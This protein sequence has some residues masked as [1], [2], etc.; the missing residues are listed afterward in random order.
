M[1]IDISED[2]VG[3]GANDVAL[4]AKFELDRYLFAKIAIEES[5]GVPEIEL[6]CSHEPFIPRFT[7]F[8]R[9]RTGS[10]LNFLNVSNK[11]LSSNIKSRWPANA[12]ADPV[13]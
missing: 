8:S 3:N 6:D 7:S 11:T 4:E 1:E 10:Y 12:V 9:A 2:G 5:P 13:G